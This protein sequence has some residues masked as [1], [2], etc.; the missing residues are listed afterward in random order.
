MKLQALAFAS[1]LASS[2]AF[3]ACEKP[4]I[5]VLPDPETAVT[6]QM[7]KAKN[8]I[9]SFIAMAEAYLACIEEADVESYN[10]MVEEMQKAAEDF[11]GIVRK[12]KTRMSG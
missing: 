11:N 6:A 3:A 7:I 10:L 12:Y 9:K 1:L 2:T 5:P 8:E 4:A